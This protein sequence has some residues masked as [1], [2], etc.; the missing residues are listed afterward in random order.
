MKEK[1]K[2][3]DKKNSTNKKIDASAIKAKTE[4]VDG[5]GASA[6]FTNVD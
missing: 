4:F 3:N 6:E 2:K 1:D 5:L